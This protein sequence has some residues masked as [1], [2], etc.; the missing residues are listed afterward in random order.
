MWS[1][2]TETQAEPDTQRYCDTL[3]P[4]LD[5][6]EMVGVFTSRECQ[7]DQKGGLF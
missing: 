6:C 7:E 1:Q 4:A 2:K 5:L 3:G